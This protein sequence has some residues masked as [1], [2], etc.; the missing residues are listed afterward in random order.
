MQRLFDIKKTQLEM[1]R[2][3]GYEIGAEENIFAMNL[4]QF[5][6]YVAELSSV[7]KMVGRSSL[8]RLYNSKEN[9]EGVQRIML[10]QYAGKANAQ[11]K[12]VPSKVVTQFLSTIERF[13][14]TEA[15][16]IIDAPLSSTGSKALLDL[17]LVKWQVFNDSDLTYNP[18]THVDTARHE[19]L[20]PEEA[21][22][23]LVE[24]KVDISK[25]LII[26]VDDPICKYYGWSSGGIVRVHRN[27]SS[28]SI[29][30]P[31]SI[32]YRI[33]VG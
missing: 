23:K 24:M 33:I 22:H 26:K 30:S 2:D 7:N 14:V 5:S 3:R 1:V 16:L 17:K 19:L 9:S 11:Q 20:S 27:D 21:R 6:S 8:S 10:V 32:N 28:L 4:E 18:S 15:V 29:L 13:G 12:Q 31:K 25:L